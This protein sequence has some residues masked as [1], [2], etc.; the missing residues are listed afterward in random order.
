MRL[1]QKIAPNLLFGLTMLL[2][3]LVIFEE[4]IQLPAFLQ[5]SGRM[6]P[7]VLH[8]P[9]GLV[10]ALGGSL[11]LKPAMEAKS[12]KVLFSGLLTLTTFCTLLTALFGLFLSLEGGYESASL[13]RHKWSGVGMAVAMY[14]W[15]LLNERSIPSAKL[16]QLGL[17]SIGILMLLAGHWGGELTHGEGYVLGPVR[18]EEVP[19]IT[20]ETSLYMAAVQP[21]LEQKCFGCHNT[22]KSKGQ[23]IMSNPALFM[24]GGEHGPSLLK[25]DPDNSLMIQRAHLPLEHEEHM[26]P[27]GKLQ[28]S[29]L[30]IQL[31]HQWI[32]SGADFNKPLGAYQE[33]DSLY[34]LATQFFELADTE[35]ATYAFEPASPALIEKLNTPFRT[36]NPVAKGSPALA[37]TIFVRKTYQPSFLQDLLQAKEQIVSLNLTDLPIQDK[38]MQILAAFPNLEK[39]ILNGTDIQGKNLNLLSANEKLAS[40]SLSNTSLASDALE[41]LAKIPSLRELFVWSAGI[42]EEDIQRWKDKLS[43]VLVH[44]G[45]FPDKSEILKLNPPRLVNK[46]NM[47]AEGEGI[48]YVHKFPGVELRYTTDGTDPDSLTSPV[49]TETIYPDQ[50][51]LLKIRA[52]SEGWQGSDVLEKSFFLEGISPTSAR[53]I[54]PTHST[55]PGKGAISL[56][57]GQKADPD[58]FRVP[59]WLG[60]KE[61]DFAAYLYFEEEVPEIKQVT[62]SYG[63]N[64]GAYI[65]PPTKVTVWGGDNERN[66][67]KLGSIKTGKIDSYVS[68]VTAGIP[69][70]IPKGKYA[71]Y[72][73]VAETLKVLPEWH[74]GA[75]TPAWIFIDEVLFY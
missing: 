75:G 15:Y 25:G 69:I 6:H 19:A 33:E 59:N 68:N 30:E 44:E 13:A 40:L 70:D 36:V 34:L 37:V 2:L 27:E 50:F 16:T 28:L 55:Y 3:F 24:A 61:T 21:V 51:T 17:V 10:V 32:Q 58:Q 43:G 9:I 39:L 18:M 72:K 1:L 65:M 4:N 45:Y 23:L 56:I 67:E 48:D 74:R 62:L 7:M 5:V 64:V 63:R 71:C 31:L 20:P 14:L 53:L 42:A 8:L 41:S 29:E 46:N 47:L 60:Y 11:L 38:D 26:P 35:N 12:F 54:Y 57:D 22:G 49:Y 52:F 66:M 73:V